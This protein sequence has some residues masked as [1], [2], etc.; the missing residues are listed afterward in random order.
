M[1]EEKPAGPRVKRREVW[2]DLPGDYEGFRFRMWVN[3]PA[4]TSLRL[5]TIR[6]V[7]ALQEMILEHNGWCDADGNPYPQ[8]DDPEFVMAIPTELLGM[9]LKLAEQE[10][11]KLPNSIAPQRR[12]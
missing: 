7:D 12:R 5:L 8:P 4:K 2:V 6:A 11:Q 9:V 3:P 10:I 1:S